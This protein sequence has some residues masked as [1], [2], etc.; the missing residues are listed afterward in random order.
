MKWTTYKQTA[1]TS[2]VE[3][4]P[5]I[6]WND[7]VNSLG[8]TAITEWQGWVVGEFVVNE[9][10]LDIIIQCLGVHTIYIDDVP[11]TGDVY[12]REQYWYSVNLKRGFHSIFIRLRAKGQQVFRCQVEQAK[13]NIE[14][15]EPRYKPDIWNGYLFSGYVALPITNLQ[16]S[17]WLKINR[18]SL[19]EQSEGESITVALVDDK[20]VSIAPG[21]TLP[22]RISWSADDKHIAKAGCDSIGLKL[23]VTSSD[24][25]LAYPISLRCRKLRESFIFT[26]LDHDGSIQHGAGNN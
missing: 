1:P 18:I 24:G 15:H 8:S 6:N 23:K 4:T 16:S 25:Q 22:V 19:Q 7:L 26:F 12:R 11:V 10:A 5:K 2:N 14:I 20:P 21:Q 3:I 17:K 9:N 13:S